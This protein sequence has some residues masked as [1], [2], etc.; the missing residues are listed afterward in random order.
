MPGV[1][2]QRPR[3]LRSQHAD[4]EPLIGRNADA[5]LAKFSERTLLIFA[6]SPHRYG[7]GRSDIRR[8]G[9]DRHRPA[10][11]AG[12]PHQS[13]PRTTYGRQQ[14]PASV[15]PSTSAQGFD[16]LHEG[17]P[18]TGVAKPARYSRFR[19]T[20]GQSDAHRAAISLQRCS[21]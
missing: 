20:W 2:N 14:R 8:S 16:R 21:T 19:P 7:T 4:I 3:A 5:G 6:R 9:R 10:G 12:K 18:R 1:E 15:W 13:R 11:A 17:L